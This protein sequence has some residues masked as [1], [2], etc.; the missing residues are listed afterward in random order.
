[1]RSR[2]V[3][4]NTLSREKEPF[5]SLR[6]GKVRMFVCGPTVQDYIHLGH[7]RTYIFYDVVARYLTH[8]GYK[9]RFVLNITDVDERITDEAK[10]TGMTPFALARKYSRAFVEDMARLKADTICRFEPV[11]KYVDKM[12]EQVSLLIRKGH[13]YAVDGWVYFDISTFPNFG[14]LSH[15]SSRELSLRPLEL[16]IRKRNLLDFSLWHPRTLVEGKWDS[17]WGMGSP[18]WHIQDIAVTASLLGPQYDLHGGAYEL[19]YPHH[20][21]E[22]AEAESLTSLRPFVK[23]WVHTRL[24]NLKGEKMSKSGGNVYTVR[25]A[26]RTYS[27]NQLR[28]FLLNRH[29]RMDMDIRGID[30]AAKAY[31]RLRGMAEKCRRA[32]GG[33]SK[34]YDEEF[35]QHFCDAMNDDFDTPLALRALSEGLASTSNTRSATAAARKLASIRLATSILGVDLGLG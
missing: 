10:R 1:M 26:L 13:A 35:L 19:I 34:E 9:V 22:I 29:Y 33:A 7:A 3:V 20:E 30:S 15:Q 24:V 27:V 8:L 16:S 21:A 17:P 18:S 31:N 23:Y 14:K 28:M 25:D 12:V 4:F 11:S 6:R 32:V 5:V 2:L